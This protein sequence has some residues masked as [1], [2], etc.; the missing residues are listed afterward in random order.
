MIKTLE[1]ASEYLDKLIKVIK[2]VLIAKLPKLPDN[3]CISRINDRCF[4]MNKSDLGN[5][6]SPEYHDFKFQYG[7]IIK[8]IKRSDS[9]NIIT[10]LKANLDQGFVRIDQVKWVLHPEVIKNIK[11]LLS[12]T[13]IKTGELK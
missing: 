10:S 13:I 3:S 12:S 8:Y 5:R 11:D 7:L 9:N 1:D 4:I 6:W 2:E